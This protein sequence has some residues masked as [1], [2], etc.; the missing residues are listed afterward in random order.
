MA[1]MTL[2]GVATAATNYVVANKISNTTYAET[3]NNVLGLLDKIGLM[4]HFDHDYT[5]KLAILDGDELEFGKDVE[6]WEFDLTLPV[7]HDP[8][9]ANTMAPHDPSAEAPSYSKSLGEKVIPTTVRY[10]NLQRAVNNAAQLGNMVANISKK[11]YDSLAV[12]KYQVKRQALADLVAKAEA[13]TGLSIV[14]SIAKPVDTNTGEAFLKQVKGDVEIAS[15]VSEGY[16]LNNNTLGA[17]QGL[18]LVIK[19]GIMPSIEVDTLA[20][21]FHE[22]RVLPKV[23]VVTIK[24]FGNNAT[25]VYAML[26]DRRILKYHNSSRYVL[27]NTNGEGGFINYFL[28]E[29]AT[30]HTSRNCFVKVYKEPSGN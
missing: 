29:E 17:T 10:N 22:D 25:G 9:G 18:V 19:Q 6:E 4:V 23:E 2:A 1:K 8:N 11:Q 3:R 7:D 16:S 15:D 12:W 20:G 21:A 27:D 30:I 14:T 26:I 28:H 13:A 24:D 5:D